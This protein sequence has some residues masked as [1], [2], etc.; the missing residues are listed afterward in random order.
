MYLPDNFFSK[1]KIETLVENKTSHALENVEVHVF[2]THQEAESIYLNFDQPVLASMF[3][4]KKIMHLQGQNSFDF[5]PGESLFLPS[6]EVM[7]IDFPEARMENPTRCLAMVIA[8]DK[9]KKTI[10][11]LNETRAKVDG[12]WT[13]HEDNFHFSNNV[14]IQQIIH[15]FMFLCT[16][17][18]SS[19]DVFADFMLSEL[20]IRILQTENKNSLTEKQ[21]TLSINNRLAFII[22]YIRQNL[23]KDLS[24]RKLSD[25]VHMSESNFH[26]VFKSELGISPIDFINCERIKLAKRLLKDPKKQIKEIYMQCGFNSPSYFFRLFKR[27]E[28]ISPKEYQIQVT[29]HFNLS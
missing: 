5:L 2:E 25:K 28:K 10:E 7:C 23:D 6:N 8:E 29:K 21:D 3:E 27:K 15:R 22:D 18:H 20:I 11:F 13:Y 4:G 9:I 1:R 14:A 19:K 12:E 24:I 17:E 16:E 26:R